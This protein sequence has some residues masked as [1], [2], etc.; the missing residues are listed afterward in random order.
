MR[1]RDERALGCILGL[2]I[3]MVVVLIQGL[4]E[5]FKYR[6]G[7]YYPA[8]PDHPLYAA[9][10]T[11]TLKLKFPEPEATK[12]GNSI[13]LSLRTNALVIVCPIMA[14]L[15]IYGILYM[16]VLNPDRY[17]FAN[18]ALLPIS[19]SL[20]FVALV[21]ARRYIF[22]PSA[23]QTR[24]A[25]LLF[26]GR[27]AAF[28]SF[29]LTGYL[30]V[31]PVV[32]GTPII[33]EGEYGVTQAFLLLVALGSWLL[34]FYLYLSYKERG[35]ALR[36]L[37]PLGGLLLFGA[38]AMLLT[39]DVSDRYLN[40]LLLNPAIQQW[41]QN[42]TVQVQLA[43]YLA[44][45][46]FA[47]VVAFAWLSKL[48]IP[49]FV[50]ETIAPEPKVGKLPTVYTIY[51]PREKPD[52]ISG[53]HLLQSLLG[54]F[55]HLT[56]QIV[57]DATSITWRIV[58]PLSHY[59]SEAIKNH[60]KSYIPHATVTT[61]PQENPDSALF[62]RQ[63]LFFRLAN[64]FTIPIPFLEHLK[65]YDPLTAITQR[66][67]LLG[68]HE[69]VT[70]SVYV[71]VATPQAKRRAHERY[72]RGYNTPTIDL[73]QDITTQKAAVDEKLVTAKLDHD[74]YHCFFVITLDAPQKKRLEALKTFVQEGEQFSNPGQNRIV[75][76]T[77]FT[78][79]K[80]TTQEAPRLED[81]DVL[82][83]GV[84]EQLRLSWRDYLL[85]LSPP[86]IAALWHTPND[87]FT[88]GKIQWGGTAAPEGLVSTDG[89]RVAIGRVSS[90][91][92]QQTIGIT[93][94]DRAYHHYIIGK[95][96]MGKSTFMHN[97]IMQDIAAGRGVAVIDPHG[98]LI[99]NVLASLSERTVDVVLLEAGS[100]S[101]PIPLNPF[102]IPPGVTFDAIRTS[103]LWALLKVYADIGSYNR[104]RL[105]LGYV[106][107]A[108]LC[109]PQA[110][111]L[112]IERVFTDDTY[113]DWLVEQ[114]DDYPTTT[115][116][117]NYI[118]RI[119]S[120]S[121]SDRAEIIDPIINR[122]GA[123]LG[124]RAL[125]N[126]TCHP[127]AL[128]FLELVKNRS[129][130]LVN[131]SGEAISS[132]AGSLAALLLSGFYMASKTLGD[133]GD[134]SAPRY[135][136][137]VDEIERV[138]TSAFS[139]LL[140]QVRK[141][142]LSLTLAHQYLDQLPGETVSSIVGNVGTLQVFE[143][144]DPDARRLAPYFEPEVERG[145]LITLG[146]YKAVVKTRYEGV[147]Q[148]AL[149]VE[150]PPPPAKAATDAT[151]GIREQT[152]AQ[153]HLVSEAEIRKALKARYRSGATSSSNGA[154]KTPPPKTRPT[155]KFE[156]FE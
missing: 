81:F 154:D 130:V 10:T 71:L 83:A 1:R 145:T 31:S 91:G 51:P 102:R 24:Q 146:A 57:A 63:H 36:R 150:T 46:V 117:Q 65:T 124:N 18:K 151:E 95:T 53:S 6:P 156:E 96:G 85:V 14:G 23:K 121:R 28:T 22:S 75:S 140:S 17:A 131:L 120:R 149:I 88:A 54:S 69:R 103:N 101:Y 40:D 44:M 97:L 105:V 48:E 107:E 73:R 29:V 94:A 20:L 92:A 15:G 60:L 19:I 34:T 114:M 39:I 41:A 68:E 122:T 37:L 123:F 56:F 119:E 2:L 47:L 110:T 72:T 21:I 115:A 67:Q 89:D 116:A 79:A 55:P 143:V 144:G 50:V 11:Q 84:D 108:L 59:S 93:Q 111:P 126:M 35:E 52:Y 118:Q 112:D 113:R 3:Y 25:V 139:E 129:I 137:Y 5:A 104:L 45:P 66:M 62:Y 135:F 16:F 80:I 100:T 90:P 127:Q 49:M 152:I 87:T 26:G 98:R 153:Q 9:K 76:Y 4:A 78:T 13:L 128:N 148:P 82:L 138:A 32:D 132:E 7:L 43:S 58:D 86:E 155:T 141:F 33:P 77:S 30:I 106:L 70:Y 99:N 27:L 74:L 147:S 38:A 136:L 8:A 109:D 12:P 134:E 142:G 42:P 133:T 64:E 125:E 61:E